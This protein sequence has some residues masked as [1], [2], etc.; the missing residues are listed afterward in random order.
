MSKY[1]TLAVAAALGVAFALPASAAENKQQ[2]KM[3][4]CQAE[5]GA[6]KLEG[7]DR[8]SFVNECLKAKPMHAD[9]MKGKSKLAS[10]MPRPRG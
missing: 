8:Q 4:T 2:S 6:K 3:A 7:K 10:A 1:L 9:K 5:A